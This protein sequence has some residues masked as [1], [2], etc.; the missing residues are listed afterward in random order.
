MAGKD[1]Y[2][3]PTVGAEHLGREGLGWRGRMDD[4]PHS[5]QGQKAK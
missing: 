5:P 1:G 3:I 2:P 4:E